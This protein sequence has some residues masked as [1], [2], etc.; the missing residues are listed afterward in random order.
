M[1]AGM[2]RE[3]LEQRIGRH[4]AFL[5]LAPVDR[6][7]LGFWVGGYYPAEQFPNGTAPWRD[8]QPL[9]PG[10]VRFADF[11]AD[12]DRLFLLHQEADDDF[13][14]V[15][16]AYWGIPWMEAVL[17]CPVVAA[18][19]NC[20]AD[21]CIA[22]PAEAQRG[23][24]ENNPWFQALLR[25]TADLA[26]F[27]AGRFPV[28][29][30]LL[31][32]PGDC[33]SAML[34]S[35][36]F[37]MGLHDEPE[38]VARLLT[39]CAR[40]RLDL[41]RALH[42]AI[43]PWHGTYAAGGYP[44]RIWCRR[45]AAYHQDDSAALLNPALFR[46]FI[47]PLHQDLCRA[48]QVNFVHLHSACLYPVDILLENRCY[49]VLEINLDH[50]GGATPSVPDLLPVLKRIQSARVPLLLWGETSPE[51]WRRLRE[52]LS[53]IGLSDDP[54]AGRCVKNEGGAPMTVELAEEID[55]CR[56]PR[57]AVRLW[58]L[59][60]A[61]FAFRTH[62]G[63]TVYVD[64]YLS[65]AVER[66]HGFKRLSLAPIAAED[67]K[68]DLVVLSHEHTDHLD[69]DA[70]PIIAANN[71]ACRFAAP[72]G[73]TPGLREAGVSPRRRVL[74]RPL[75]VHPLDAVAVHTAPADHG[76]FAPSAL[77]LVLNFSGVRVLYTGDTSWRSGLFKPLLDLGIDVLLPC[78]NG[79]FGNMNHLDAARLVQQAAPRMAVPCHFWTFAEQGGG[80]P[81]GFVHACRQFAPKTRALLLR[82]G[83]GLTVRRKD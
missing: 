49:D 40:V 32:G 52:T 57:G 45:R 9:Q 72:A 82:P 80:D 21:V 68:A 48:A 39:R 5:N 18:S 41:I 2:S 73:C 47:L 25:F 77:A 65:D 4:E 43:P 75:R 58:W 6:P 64:P 31:R 56:V 7:L 42:A 13:F 74:L 59:G 46:R 44:S 83:E 36:P 60:Q 51:E 50:P 76:D 24:L 34:G 70:I 30:P 22:E 62:A 8:G 38:P 14:Y 69:P 79:T 67:V 23:G 35:T 1:E 53:P 71:P 20:R 66:L 3:S 10:D 16:S 61:G 17:G 27:S 12:Y 11:A 78:I 15:G 19:A 81:G 63:K 37:V 54:A 28:C 55:R 26:S 29:P 33:A